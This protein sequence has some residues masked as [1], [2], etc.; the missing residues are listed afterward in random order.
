MPVVPNQFPPEHYAPFDQ[1]GRHA[2]RAVLEHYRAPI[3][4]QPTMTNYA[5]CREFL[6]KLFLRGETY[7][8]PRGGLLWIGAAWA[9]ANNREYIIEAHYDMAGRIEG[10][11]FRIKGMP[12]TAPSKGAEAFN[13]RKCGRC[14]LIPASVRELNSQRE[15]IHQCDCGARVSVSGGRVNALP[16]LKPRQPRQRQPRNPK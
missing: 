10:Y 6:D 7:H 12:G 8:S 2:A 9:K 5:R 11:L 14:T 4:T 1:D 16:S 13:C 15:W 3:G